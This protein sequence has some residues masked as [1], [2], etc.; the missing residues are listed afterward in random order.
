MKLTQT[1]R[2]HI[3]SL[4]DRKGRL[5][6]KRLLAD[7]RQPESPLHSLPVFKNWDVEHATEKW[8][9][10]CARLVIASVTIQVTHNDTVLKTPVYIVDTDTKGDGYRSVVSLKA[11]TPSARESLVYTLEVA[12]GH[13]RRAYDLA[14][15]LGLGKSIDALLAQV[16]GVKRIAEGKK[17]A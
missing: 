15:P 1:Q 4:E 7:A 2:A 16:A 9:L 17:A 13:L 11:D 6:A 12:A 14:V 10:H 5:T 8:W 3:K